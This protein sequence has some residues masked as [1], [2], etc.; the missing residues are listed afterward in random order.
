MSQINFV[1][2]TTPQGGASPQWQADLSLKASGFYPTLAGGLGAGGGNGGGAGWFY[3]GGVLATQTIGFTMDETTTYN[4]FYYPLDDTSGNAVQTL[5]PCANVPGKVVT[6]EKVSATGNT[7]TVTANGTEPIGVIGAPTTFVLKNQGDRVTL[8]STG[9]TALG[10]RILER[11]R[12]INGLLFS[13]TVASAAI[14]GTNAETAFD[15]NA[16][17]TI[18]ANTLKAGDIIRLST[19]GIITGHNG[20]DTLAVQAYVGAQSIAT[21]GAVN[22]SANDTFGFDLEFVVRTIGGSGTMLVRGWVYDGVPGTATAKSV[23]LASTAIDTT[24]TKLL[25][26]TGTFSSSSGTNSCR[27]DMFRVTRDAA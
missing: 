10:W 4:G 5:Q 27:N 12:G 17:Y 7:C 14:T 19:M 8:I 23:Y 9:V 3:P 21:T 13:Q 26:L 18:P 6:F 2:Q 1:T 20:S 11:Y 25:K 24:A 15:T 16:Q 22:N